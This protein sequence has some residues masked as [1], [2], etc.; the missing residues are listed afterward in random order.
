MDVG[1]HT[2][3]PFE[4]ISLNFQRGFSI[5]Y[6]QAVLL[7]RTVVNRR[8]PHHA[9]VQFSEQKKLI[10]NIENNINFSIGVFTLF[11]F[12]VLCSLIFRFIL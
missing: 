1:L 10:S 5:L 8:I 9:Q 6:I 12:Q 11:I 7:I 4:F 2:V 3:R